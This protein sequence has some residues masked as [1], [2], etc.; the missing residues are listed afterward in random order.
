M[1]SRINEGQYYWF[2]NSWDRQREKDSFI[3]N[4]KHVKR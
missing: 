2:R 1:E 3:S 4:D